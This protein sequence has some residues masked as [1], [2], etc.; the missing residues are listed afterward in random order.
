MYTMFFLSSLYYR[1][2]IKKRLWIRSGTNGIFRKN[3]NLSKI[4]FAQVTIHALHDT[5]HNYIILL[6]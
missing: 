3:M 1:G 4:W 6:K 2:I 5:I